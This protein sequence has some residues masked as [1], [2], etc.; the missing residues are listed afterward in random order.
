M[1]KKSD[2]FTRAIAKAITPSNKKENI[3]F[4]RLNGCVELFPMLLAKRE[5]HAVNIFAVLTRFE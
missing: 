4:F 2:A 5:K 1:E 3:F